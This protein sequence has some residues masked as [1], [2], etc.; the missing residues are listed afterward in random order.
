MKKIFVFGSKKAIALKKFLEDFFKGRDISVEEVN[1]SLPCDV[2][3]IYDVFDEKHVNLLKNYINTLPPNVI[4]ANGDVKD[5]N[6]LF[7]MGFSFTLITAGLNPKCT[8]TASSISYEE[9][10]YR[11]NY[12]VQRAFNNLK[13]QLIEPMEIPVEIKTLEQ[14]NIYNSLFAVTLLTLLEGR[15]KFFESPVIIG[16]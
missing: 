15:E 5:V 4:I 10:G 13:G 3:V 16:V 7:D 1:Y 6:L 12:C 8:A 11:F 2:L 14:Y 9:G